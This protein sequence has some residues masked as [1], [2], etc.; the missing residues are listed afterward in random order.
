[1]SGWTHFLIVTGALLQLGGLGL[2]V[3]QVQLVIGIRETVRQQLHELGRQLL[4]RK[5]RQ[6]V[7]VNVTVPIGVEISADVEVRYAGES[8]L[9]WL[10]REVRQNRNAVAELGRKFERKIAELDNRTQRGLDSRLEMLDRETSEKASRNAVLMWWGV[11]LIGAGITMQ[12]AGSL[13]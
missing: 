9:E 6:S 8:E 3:R 13:L 12:T 11:V 1:M 5:T 10:A 4:G 7:T 2:T